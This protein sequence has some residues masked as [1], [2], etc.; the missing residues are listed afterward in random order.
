L[1]KIGWWNRKVYPSH[2]YERRKVEDD[3]KRFVGWQSLGSLLQK[4]EG[5]LSE[6]D[7]ALFAVT[8]LTGGRIQE[9]LAL[10]SN[11]FVVDKSEETVTVQDMMLLKRYEKTGEY[12]ERVEEKPTNKLARLFKWDEEKQ[13]W[14]RTR[15]E[16]E[17]KPDIR[18]DF[19]LPLDEPFVALLLAKLE[20]TNEFLFPGYRAKHLSYSRAY[21]IITKV[22]I[23][24]HWL[25]AQRASCLISFYRMTME[26]MM[27]WMG[28]EELSTARHYAKFGVKALVSKMK[29]RE[30]PKEAYE[31]A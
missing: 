28:W 30:Y 24:P 31:F 29:K 15:Y 7:R 18:P 20:I 4:F 5:Y 9:V 10:R 14:W 11:N 22:G 3:V 17:G 27:E 23:Y 19:S 16:T 2:V 12:I 8:F 25:R 13:R 1:K 21:Q 26:E 6:R